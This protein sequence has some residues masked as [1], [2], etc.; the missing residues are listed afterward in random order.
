MDLLTALGRTI[1]FAL[2]SGVNLYATVAVLGLVAR[3]GWVDLPPAFRGFEHP[4]IIGAALAMYLVEFL[5]DKI[6]WVD[7]VWDAAHT[8]IRPLGGA[9]VAVTALGETSAAMQALVAVLGGS[10]AMTTHLSKTGTRAIA[11]TSP[12]PFSNWALSLAED[13]FVV[14]FSWMALQHP[15]LAL[16]VSVIVLTAIVLAASALY[17]AVR[18]RFVRA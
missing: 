7:S 9:V 13:L 8:V 16:L 10:V 15:Y 11:N 12:E 2:A 18:R 5:A 17:R 6:P 14:G 1:P 3:F 4:A